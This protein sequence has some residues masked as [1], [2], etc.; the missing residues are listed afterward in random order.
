MRDNLASRLCMGLVLTCLSAGFVFASEGSSQLGAVDFAH[1]NGVLHVA[2][3]TPEHTTISLDN[4]P[5]SVLDSLVNFH[6]YQVFAIDGEPFQYDYGRPAIP[7]ITRLYRI[8]NTGGVELEITNSDFDVIDNVDALPIQPDEGTF[9]TSPQVDQSVYDMDQWYP[10]Q[11]AVMSS[12]KIF[13]DFRVVKVTLYPVQ[14]NPV[15]HQARVYRNLDAEINTNGEPGE[16]ELLRPRRPSGAFAP[17]YRSMIANLDDNA[18]DDMTTTPGSILFLCKSGNADMRD[19]VDSLATWKR[20]LGYDVVVDSSHATWS[21]TQIHNAIEDHYDNDDP[22]LEFACIIGNTTGSYIMPTHSGTPSQY[23]HYYAEMTGDDIEDVGVGRLPAVSLAHLSIIRNKIFA[24]E[25]TPN[26]ADTMWYHRAFLYA[27]TGESCISNEK[28]MEWGKQ[29]FRRRTGVDSSFVLTTPGD[30][31]NVV[32]GRWL[33]RGISYFLWRGSVVGEMQNTAASSGTA[34]TKLPVALTIT[35]GSGDFGDGTGISESWMLAGTANNL[36]GG[37]CG[38]GTFTWGTHVHYNNTVAGGLVYGIA[39][40]QVQHLGLALASAKAQL[41]SAFADQPA[42]EMDYYKNFIY[43]NNL[44]GDPSLYMWTARPTYLNVSYPTTLDVGARQVRPQVTDSLT[45]L[46]IANALIVLWKGDE[47]YSR[48]LTDSQGFAD[49]PVTVNTPGTMTLT[50]SKYNHKP[51]LADIECANAAQMVAVSS[52]ALDD[53]NIDGTTGNND[54][55]MNPGETIDLPIY[56]RNFGDTQTATEIS[57]T[58]T[59]SNPKVT[60]VTGTS[61]YADLAPGDSVLGAVPFRIQVSA[62]MGHRESVI[63]TLAVVTTG[64]VNHSSFELTARGGMAELVSQA[65]IGGNNDNHLDPDETANLRITVRNVGALDMN[66]VTGVLHSYSSYVSVGAETATFGT[67]A[68]DGTASNTG[69]EFSVSANNMTY[70]GHVAPLV[71]ILTTTDGFVDSVHLS[72]EVGVRTTRDPTGPDAYGYFAYEDVDTAY[73][74]HRVFNYDSINSDGRGTRLALNDPGIQTTTT[75]YSVVRPLPFSFRFYGQDYDSI[76]ICSNGWAALGVQ[77]ELDMFRNYAIPGEQAADAMICPFWDDL[78]TSG[79]PLG[80]WDYSETDSDRYIIQWKARG[81]EEA[82]GAVDDFEV[83][84]LDPARYPTRDGNGIVMMQYKAVHEVTVSVWDVQYSTMGIVAPGGTVGLQYRFSNYPAPGSTDGTGVGHTL[85][86]NRCVVYTTDSRA[87]FGNIAG[88][89]TDAETQLPMAGVTVFIPSSNYTDT[90]DAQGHYELPEVLIGTYSVRARKPGFNDCESQNIVVHLDSTTALD[91]ALP[92]PEIAFSV[93]HIAVSLP[94]EPAQTSFNVVNNG[95]GQ[96]DYQIH[97]AFS[98]G[99]T[100]DNPWDFTT[101][102]DVSAPTGDQLIYGCELVGDYWWLT[103]GSGPDGGKYFYRFD[104]QGNY[105]NAI[106]QP[107]ELGVGWFDLAYDGQY[108]YGSN[109]HYLY[110]VDEQGVVRDSILSPCNPSRAVAYDPQSGHFWVAD[111]NSDIAEITRTGTVL[112]RFANHY[113]VTG[114]AWNANDPLGYKLY[115]FGMDSLNN[116]AQIR[117]MHPVSSDVQFITSLDRQPGDRA[118]GCAITPRWNSTMLVFAGVLQNSTDDVLGIWELDFNTSWITVNPT[119]GHVP[120]TA[121]D[122]IALSF[123]PQSLR[124]GTYNVNLEFINNS[125]TPFATLPVALTVNISGT[126]DHQPVPREYRLFQNY[127]NPFNSATT[128]RYDLKTGGPTT[129]RVFNL[130]GEQVATVVNG[131][132][133]AGSHTVNFETNGMASGMYLY[134]LESGTFQQTRKLM[135]IR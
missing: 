123:D 60:V 87:A 117:R 5:V 103:G 104:L 13:R 111:Y 70:P 133:E 1:S 3:V 17:L 16:R 116:H 97:I 94:T 33:T 67:I 109:S 65:V 21:T 53:D 122:D 26:M 75:N 66:G 57:A 64:G 28:T 96:L 44:L 80:V 23:D 115:I 118:G 81:A 129:L 90:A 113:N 31:D 130:L 38:I 63:L 29:Q 107:N 11:I 100:L 126:D 56:L 110:G 82:T 84:L 135:L 89:V 102:F 20:R 112:H 125:A 124:N 37:I 105:V 24:Y 22:P 49:V 119:G 32:I 101:G 25:R 78:K 46:P 4:P 50:V 68:V 73:E 58:L 14:V 61:T 34:S 55:Q 42:S 15:T 98:P 36:K 35:C 74:M 92:H 51:F 7:Q 41:V 134:R 30:V 79:T 83:I 6:N 86:S 45:G 18:L 120:A 27:G 128:L 48:A 54:H 91:F 71:L 76:T 40:Q 121:T 62:S 93:D 52:Y 9:P 43:W 2:S 8:P 132:E 127:P 95:N 47:C 108:L 106:P 39:D 114:L 10:P 69:T 131:F 19:F 85:I 77:R 88:T 99:T 59:S 72:L 12:P